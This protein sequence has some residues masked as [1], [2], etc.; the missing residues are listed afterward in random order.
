MGRLMADAKPRGRV[1]TLGS[2]IAMQ[3]DFNKQRGWTDRKYMKFS[4]DKCQILPWDGNAPCS[5]GWAAW[6]IALKG[7]G[8]ASRITAQCCISRRAQPERQGE[9][10]SYSALVR[11]YLSSLGLTNKWDISANCKESRKRPFIRG[12]KKI[13]SQEKVSAWRGIWE[14][15]TTAFW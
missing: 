9:Y 8:E 4:K 10:C 13:K 11:L 1:S 12:L 7:P 2:S 6:L 3:K 5:W 15:L 14:N